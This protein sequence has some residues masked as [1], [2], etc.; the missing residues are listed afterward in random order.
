MVEMICIGIQKMHCINNLSLNC[1]QNIL[2]Y[3]GLISCGQQTYATELS[4]RL[5]TLFEI[6]YCTKVETLFNHNTLLNRLHKN[7]K[8][9]IHRFLHK[10]NL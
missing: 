6:L 7:I 9:T 5:C 10:Y 3:I 4:D 2:V 8:L 1:L